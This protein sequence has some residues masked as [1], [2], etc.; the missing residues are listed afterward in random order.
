V[1]VGE[2]RR[3]AAEWRDIVDGWLASG[4]SRADY[5]RHVGVHPSTLGW[6][7]WKFGLRAA[8]GAGLEVGRPVFAEVVVVPDATAERAPDFVIELEDVRVRVAPGFDAME[9]RRLL[10]TLC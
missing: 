1:V 5:A 4:W 3:S 9:L 2:W 6:W 7:R 10:A 8:V